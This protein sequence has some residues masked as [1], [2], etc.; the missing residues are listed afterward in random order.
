M[1]AWTAEDD[2]VLRRYWSKVRDK[3]E[4]ARLLGGRHTVKAITE[5]ARILGVR[6]PKRKRLPWE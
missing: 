2:S 6:R 3:F 5:R 1:T 4:V